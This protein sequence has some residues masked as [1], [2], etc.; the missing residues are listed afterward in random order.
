MA[1]LKISELP[2]IGG[3][4]DDYPFAVVDMNSSP[5]TTSKVTITGMTFQ[6]GS[7]VYNTLNGIADPSTPILFLGDATEFLITGDTFNTK[8]IECNIITSV[9]VTYRTSGGSA[10]D[11]SYMRMDVDATAGTQIYLTDTANYWNT[12][13][14]TGRASNLTNGSHTID[15]YMN[16]ANG[17]NFEFAQITLSAYE[18]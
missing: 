8:R 9:M 16:L 14:F 15:L 6:G 1:N 12:I 7:T 10:G 11:L 2:G 5:I 4:Q 3:I 13:S 17:V 18:R